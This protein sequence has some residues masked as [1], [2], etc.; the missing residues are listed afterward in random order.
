MKNSFTRT[1]ILAVLA[2]S[3]F[4]ACSKDDKKEDSTSNDKEVGLA[5]AKAVSDVYFDDV[6]QE[7]LQ[8]NTESG[9]TLRETQTCA[10]VTITPQDATFPKTVTIDFGAGCT[11]VNGFVRKGKL[12]YTINKKF[13]FPG[14]TATVTFDNY[15]VNDY[16]LEGTYTLANNGSLTGLSMT[17]TLVNGK[18]TYP[19]GTWF[20]RSSVVNWVQVAGTDTPLDFTNDEFNIT[21][22]GTVKSSAG[23][24]LTVSTETPLLRKFICF[25]IVSGK[26]TL[27][28]NNINGVLDYG[29][30]AC[31]K[32]AT[33]TIGNK[34]YAV[35]LP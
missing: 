6:S 33:L 16:K 21:G 14:A 13:A 15:S 29:T 20:T 3:V 4:Q 18:I 22:S 24:E 27:A 23:N 9:L 1:L 35:S 32:T 5:N 8:V 19:D 12:I 10:T 30:G 34:D 25:N 31:D 17:A 26:L 2:I 11:G 7:V 28:F